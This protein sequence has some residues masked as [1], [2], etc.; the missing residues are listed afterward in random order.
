MIEDGVGFGPDVPPYYLHPFIFFP[1]QSARM[2]VCGRWPL[3]LCGPVI[4]GMFLPLMGF[5]CVFSHPFST[6]V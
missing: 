5:G 6:Q 4:W 3:A 1:M 2:R